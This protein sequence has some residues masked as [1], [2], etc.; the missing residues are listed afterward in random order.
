MSAMVG[1]AE[2]LNVVK[3]TYIVTKILASEILQAL[4]PSIS[5]PTLKIL[6]ILNQYFKS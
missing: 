4:F 5:A 1:S 6:W 3:L 2:W